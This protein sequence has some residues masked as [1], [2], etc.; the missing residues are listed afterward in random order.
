MQ[1]SAFNWRKKQEKPKTVEE[2]HRPKND[3]FSRTNTRVDMMRPWTAQLEGGVL[4]HSRTYLQS[5]RERNM[6]TIDA[7]KRA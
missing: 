5:L 4:A 6:D 3:I 2:E 1:L 7:V